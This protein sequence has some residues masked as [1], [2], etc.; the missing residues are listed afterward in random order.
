MGLN[1]TAVDQPDSVTQRRAEAEPA[2]HLIDWYMRRGHRAVDHVQWLGKT[3]RS[4]ALSKPLAGFKPLD[5]N[6]K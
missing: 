2:T 3:Y 6:S 1:H 4:V 5:V